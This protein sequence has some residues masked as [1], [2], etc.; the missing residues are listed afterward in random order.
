MKSSKSAYF[1]LIITAGFLSLVSTSTWA[2]WTDDYLVGGPATS[3]PA[4]SSWGSGRLD[5][6]YC[7]SD[8]T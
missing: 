8:N 2:T 1:Q 7:G 3:G 6:F 5:V 4:I